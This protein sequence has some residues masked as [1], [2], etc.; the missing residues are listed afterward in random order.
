VRVIVLGEMVGITGTWLQVLQLD[1]RVTD[2]KPLADHAFNG[3]HH[4][5][6]SSQWLLADDDVAAHRGVLRGDVPDMDV[7]RRKDTVRQNPWS[8]RFVDWNWELFR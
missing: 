8:D 4:A 1:G 7:V 3:P 5:L 6:R 2:A